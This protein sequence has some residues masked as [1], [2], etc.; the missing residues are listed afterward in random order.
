IV[1]NSNSSV[2][3]S[4]GE[5]SDASK[6]PVPL[7]S[8]KELDDA[9]TQKR[10]NLVMHVYRELARDAA[11]GEVDEEELVTELCKT[12]S[13]LPP[14]YSKGDDHATNTHAYRMNISRQYA[15]ACV[16]AAVHKGLLERTVAD[17][18]N[19]NSSKHMLRSPAKCAAAA[20]SASDGSIPV[21]TSTTTAAATT[22]ATA[23]APAAPTPQHEQQQQQQNETFATV[24]QLVSPPTIHFAPGYREGEEIV[25]YGTAG[26]SGSS[27]QQPQ[28]EEYYVIGV[29]FK[30]S[31]DDDGGPTV[32]WLCPYCLDRFTLY[33][34]YRS[35]IKDLHHGKPF[36]GNP[37]E[38]A[39]IDAR[40]GFNE[41][42]MKRAY[43]DTW[44]CTLCSR[45]GDRWYIMDHD[46]PHFMTAVARPSHSPQ[47]LP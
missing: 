7:A 43:S 23:A 6:R 36:I 35:H 44:E 32:L 25:A 21:V 13:F 22:S 20:S 1:N 14:W 16:S 5:D 9:V 46:C 39:F 47:L 8:E 18:D 34:Y 33:F 19:N 42:N 2:A 26:S 28:N 3:S 40:R 41:K 10:I 29:E 12:G 37:A 30:H 15:I 17:N 24:E 31:E 38:E 11:G 4:S 45:R 27:G